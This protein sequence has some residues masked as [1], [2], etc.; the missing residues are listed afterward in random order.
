MRSI[1]G[2]LG[3]ESFPRVRIGVGGNKGEDLKKHVL[4]KPGKEDQAQLSSAF[5]DAAQAV[6]LI[7]EGKLQE[8]QAKYN[9]RHI[10]GA[11]AD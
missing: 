1:I 7:L 10:G 9:K 6:R 2:T 3:N 8:A 11:K 5:C 4:G